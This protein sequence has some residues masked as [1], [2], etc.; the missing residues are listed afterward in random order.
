MFIDGRV[1]DTDYQERLGSNS[2][3]EPWLPY[4]KALYIQPDNLV[5]SFAS[6]SC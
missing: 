4:I 6:F 1:Y 3:K 5:R 2:L